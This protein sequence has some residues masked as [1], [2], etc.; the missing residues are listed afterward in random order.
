[1]HPS[2]NHG[3][4]PKRLSAAWRPRAQSAT[5]VADPSPP[6][7]L[8]S[9]KST[10][11]LKL[12]VQ[13]DS[14]PENDSATAMP[15]PSNEGPSAELNLMDKREMGSLHPTNVP[16]TR[17]QSVP[18]IN[19]FD[20]SLNTNTTLFEIE[21]V[22]FPSTIINPNQ[23]SKRYWD[24]LIMCIIIYNAV[25][26]PLYV[27]F[28]N[29][30]AGSLGILDLVFDL[31]FFIDIIINFRTAY[32]DK[33]VMVVDGKEIARNY[34]RNWFVIDVISILPYEFM[35]N[36]F[37]SG[38]IS[39]IP[40]LLRILR[41]IRLTRLMRL[42]RLSR[43]FHKWFGHVQ[44]V[45]MTLRMVKLTAVLFFMSHY[46]ACGYIFIANLDDSD[47]TS[48]N[49]YRNITHQSDGHVEI[50]TS[51]LHWA[52]TTITTVGYGDI[53]P[54][55]DTERIYT[56]LNMLIGVT[57]FTFVVGSMSA[58]IQQADHSSKSK[59]DKLDQVNQWLKYRE[60]PA[61]IQYRVREYYNHIWSKKSGFFDESALL[62]DL[63]V[64]LRSTITLWLNEQTLRNIGFFSKL[65]DAT[66][67]GIISK[68]QPLSCRSGD[69]LVR[70]GQEGYC[71]YIISRGEVDV[72]SGDGRKRYRTL[73]S[74][75]Y[76]G[77]I[78]LIN[79]S[80]RRTATVQAK[81]YCELFLLSKTIF[82]AAFFSHIE[83]RRAVRSICRVV[84]LRFAAQSST[85]N[86]S[87]YRSKQ[88]L[89]LDM[90][91]LGYE[92]ENGVEI[93]ARSFQPQQN[94]QK[95]L[96]SLRSGPGSV[97]VYGQR[98]ALSELDN[99]ETKSKEDDVLER[100]KLNKVH[101]SSESLS[102]WLCGM[103]GRNYGFCYLY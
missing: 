51:A 52:V 17:V 19:H 1:M 11:S 92:T 41:L 79:R 80:T 62:K 73:G 25:A 40:R 26:I 16:P 42:F 69:Y 88:Y 70:E 2:D 72:T 100:I 99:I 95:S 93:R 22:I 32:D 102:I 7:A 37:Q 35:L 55:T 50:Y 48:W 14:D 53:V 21:P 39:R 61:P 86:A 12:A 68:M 30:T 28:P 49:V 3:S 54:K 4:A 56:I 45:Q 87:G 85:L 9:D 98:R 67:S 44:L 91:A 18:N 36:Q 83:L 74:G 89:T 47:R 103:V 33:G 97:K 20:P 6:S 13:S 8:Q 75:G 78:A 76:F 66:L 81:T 65:D 15:S 71:M 64:A 82:D 23:N 101:Q 84:E 46:S 58:F 34:L 5:S 43:I 27:A 60:L 24:V 10:E 77:E 38:S 90:A 31:C 94:S 57:T 63:P 29:I 96:S 59:K